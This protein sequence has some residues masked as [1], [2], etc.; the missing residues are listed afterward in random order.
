MSSRGQL[1]TIIFSLPVSSH[2]LLSQVT[3]RGSREIGVEGGGSGGRTCALYNRAEL[4]LKVFILFKEL[5]SF[6]LKPI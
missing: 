4:M 3:V 1:C 2:L 6:L 5:P